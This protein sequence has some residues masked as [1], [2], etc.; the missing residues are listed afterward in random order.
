MKTHRVAIK[1][2][3]FWADTLPDWPT[4]A[5]VIRGE[6]AAGEPT[7]RPSP[8]RLAPAE[9]RR[10]PDSVCV[11]LQAADEAVAMSGIHATALTNV[12][13]SAQGDLGLT[14]YMCDTLAADPSAVS[15]TKFHNSVHNAPVGYWSIANH[16]QHN[17]TSICAYDTSFAAGLLEA[18]T[19]SATDERPVLYCAYDI[20]ATGALA[21]VTR[22]ERLLGVALVLAPSG[23][24]SHQISWSVIDSDSAVPS[25]TSSPQT[26]TGQDLAVNAM[27]DALPF[28]E[29]LAVLIGNPV[30]LRV[31]QA[32]SLRLE[33]TR[34]D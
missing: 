34:I 27:A 26:E 4:A 19:L 18:L 22:S 21:E 30:I 10:A 31:G 20:A 23:P 14:D 12:F 5:A 28:Y 3:G 1:G 7:K 17:S 32:T 16:T 24:G 13:A 8:A 9:R 29:E 15:P 25:D 11:A 6:A 33:L 2:I